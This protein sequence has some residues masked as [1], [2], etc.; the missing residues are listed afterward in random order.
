MGAGGRGGAASQLCWRGGRLG[1][2]LTSTSQKPRGT[3]YGRGG[4]VGK[5]GSRVRLTK[6]L[7]PGCLPGRPSCHLGVQRGGR[8]GT[9]GGTNV[10]T[11]VPLRQRGPARWTERCS[12]EAVCQSG[13]RRARPRPSRCPL[14]LPCAGPGPARS[15]D[16]SPAPAGRWRA[17]CWPHAPR[18]GSRA[19]EGLILSLSGFRFFAGGLGEM[20]SSSE[21]SQ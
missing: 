3:R 5:Q 10:V 18:K 13:R 12:S 14:P 19:S 1:A 11:E 8:H 6:G 20:P 4:Q 21:I 7:R 17:G 16:S 15:R 2:L 9:A